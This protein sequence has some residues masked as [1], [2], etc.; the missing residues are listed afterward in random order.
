MPSGM[1]TIVVKAPNQKIEDQQIEAD[2]QWTVADFKEK[3]ST[4]YPTQLV[5]IIY[6][7]T[8]NN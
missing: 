1:V 2:V 4:L 8:M 7:C 3:L 6:Y 5:C